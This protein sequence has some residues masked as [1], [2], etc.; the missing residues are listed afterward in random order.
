MGPCRWTTNS[1]LPPKDSM[2]VHVAP[3]TAPDTQHHT[4]LLGATDCR[5]HWSMAVQK[6]PFAVSFARFCGVP[7]NPLDETIWER[8][9]VG[10][11]S[12]V[13]S[14]ESAITTINEPFHSTIRTRPNGLESRR[15]AP[16]VR[17][18]QVVTILV[19]IKPLETT[20][21]RLEHCQV[22]QRARHNRSLAPR[23]V[24]GSMVLDATWTWHKPMGMALA[25]DACPLPQDVI[26]LDS[27]FLQPCVL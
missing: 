26:N 15:Q 20:L 3:P 13:E 6:I 5:F 9:Q 22:A 12:R 7:D 27:N 10:I 21:R 4:R 1:S 25:V 17:L 11:D 8:L 23:Q 16:I 14:T 19:S 2:L 24:N 18:A